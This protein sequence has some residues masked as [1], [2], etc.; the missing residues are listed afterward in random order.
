MSATKIAAS[1]RVSLTALMPRSPDRRVAVAWAWLRF[2]AALGKTWKQGMQAPRVDWPVYPRH[3]ELI[4]HAEEGNRQL[5]ILGRRSRVNRLAEA[6]PKALA[7][8]DGRT[9]RGPSCTKR[10]DARLPGASPQRQI[11]SSHCGPIHRSGLHA[12]AEARI[13]RLKSRI[14]RPVDKRRASHPLPLLQSQ[15]CKKA[16]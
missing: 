10:G 6:D 16:E 3:I 1:F 12:G 14:D 2:H 13:A 5:A 9:R 4:T 11:A 7:M 8:A 15:R